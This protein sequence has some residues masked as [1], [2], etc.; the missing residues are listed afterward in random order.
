MT[1]EKAHVPIKNP[2]LGSVVR[3]MQPIFNRLGSEEFLVGCERCIDRNKNECL[4][5]VIWGMAPVKAERVN[6]QTAKHK[7]ADTP[8]FAATTKGIVDM[9]EKNKNCL[10]L[11]GAP[12]NG[13]SLIALSIG[14]TFKKFIDIGNSASIFKFQSA[15]IRDVS[16][17][18]K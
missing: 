17:L 11:H 1:W 14:L 4:H 8:A 15:V 16:Y 2:L 13:K 9:T 6:K 10:Y 5:H 18:K 7:R 3:L 12:N